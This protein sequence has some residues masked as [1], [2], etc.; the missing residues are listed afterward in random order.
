M[1]GYIFVGALAAFG[2]VCAVWV[3]CGLVQ[4]KQGKGTLCF[5]GTGALT[6]ARRYI[7]LRE[8]GLI[9]CPLVLLDPVDADREWLEGQGIELCSRED[10]AARLGIGAEKN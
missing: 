4:P 9:H 3:L 5:I 2:L 7:W 8:M 1:A 6:V 10:L